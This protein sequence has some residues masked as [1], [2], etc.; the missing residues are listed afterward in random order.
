MFEKTY[1]NSSEKTLLKAVWWLIIAWSTKFWLVLNSC[2][3]GNQINSLFYISN[4]IYISVYSAGELL[5]DV[6]A[7]IRQC[8]EP[9]IG[10]DFE[11]V[12]SIPDML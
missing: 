11:V 4:Y 7:A 3:I 2:L 10:E 1:T 8:W 6:E 12:V 9:I 5:P